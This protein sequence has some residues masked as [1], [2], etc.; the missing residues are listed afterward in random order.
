MP[1]PKTH[2]IFYKQLKEYLNKEA[3][4]VF[5]NYDDYSIFAQGHDLLIYHDFYKIHNQAQLGRNIKLSKMLQEYFFSE[6]VYCYLKCAEEMDV[7][8]NEQ[9]RLFIGPGYVGHHILD[10]YTHPLIIYFA[11]DHVRDSGRKT[12]RHGI[13]ENLIDIYLMKHIEKVDAHRYRVYK[14]FVF[15]V[16]EMAEEVVRVLDK[17]LEAVYGISNG[18]KGFTKACS[19]VS[20]YMRFLKYDPI[21]AKRIVFDAVDPLLKGTASFS[22]CRSVEDAREFLNQGHEWWVNPMTDTIQSQA[23][24]MELY[25]KALVDCG[26]IIE[27]LE[28]LCKR[29][30]IEREDICAIIPNI[31]STHG[32][33]CGKTI[34][35]KYT[36]EMGSHDRRQSKL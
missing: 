2:Q 4:E 3:L 23:S 21:G 20:Q 28:V 18:G 12:W 5:P 29:G 31:A 6:F 17:S 7:L 33:S 24:F 13:A 30:K 15:P 34:E 22:Y 36:K 9:V 14:D 8:D 11:G 25:Q 26:I 10:A 35:I 27:K 19:Q 32:L 16:G 1:G